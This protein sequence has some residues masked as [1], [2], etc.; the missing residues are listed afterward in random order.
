MKE[1]ADMMR[2]RTMRAKERIENERILPMVDIILEGALKAADTGNSFTHAYYE[3]TGVSRDEI[4][5]VAVSL[6]KLG[7]KTTFNVHD[8]K[9]TVEW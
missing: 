6:Q 9:L 7:Y 4:D 2:K 5:A 8:Q 3:K 1:T